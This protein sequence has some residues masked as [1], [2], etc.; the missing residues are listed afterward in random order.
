MMILLTNKSCL[1]CSVR[2][3]PPRTECLECWLLDA[4]VKEVTRCADGSVDS[5][6]GRNFEEGLSPR[7][8]SDQRSEVRM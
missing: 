6:A 4:N 3:V 2:K 1:V 8:L 5:A 7:L